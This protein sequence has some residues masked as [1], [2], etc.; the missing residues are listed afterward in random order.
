MQKRLKISE[1]D[2]KCWNLAI[3]YNF[4]PGELQIF[5]KWHKHDEKSLK[6]G[7]VHDQ[8]YFVYIFQ[9]FN[10]YLRKAVKRHQDDFTLLLGFPVTQEAENLKWHHTPL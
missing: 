9:D 2:Q 6:R 7:P 10:G 5:V 3:C 4:N 8:K 1:R